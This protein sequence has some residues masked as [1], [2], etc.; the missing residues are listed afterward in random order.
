MQAT[1]RLCG[2][3]C[4]LETVGR[5]ILYSSFRKVTVSYC[6]FV[7]KVL[8]WD[9]VMSFSGSVMPNIYCGL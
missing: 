4:L 9:S 7:A 2:V 1:D 3:R 8:L 5:D 6:C